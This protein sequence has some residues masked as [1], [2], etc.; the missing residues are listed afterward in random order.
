MTINVLICDDEPANAHAWSDNIASTTG[1][2]ANVDVVEKDKLNKN[3]AI[4]INRQRS[5]R[6]EKPD[7]SPSIFD[8]AD[9]LIADY[10]LLY[11]DETERVTG[12]GIAR[13]VRGLTGCGPIIVLN[14]NPDIDFDLKMLGD[15]D[16]L[17]DL[18][19][20]AKHA[21]AKGLWTN[22][23]GVG[24]RPWHWP[25][26]LKEVNN[27]R[28]RIASLIDNLDTPILEFFKFN[29]ERLERI[30]RSA[31]GFLHPTKEPHIVTFRDFVLES[32]NAVDRRMA[33]DVS[34]D[35]TQICSIAA[36][37]IHKWLER[38]VLGPQNV[39]VDM[40]HLVSRYP[41]LLQAD[42]SILESY[43]TTCDISKLPEMLLIEEVLSMQFGSTAWLSR[44]AFWWADIEDNDKIQ[45]MFDEFEFPEI[46][47]VFREDTSDFSIES[48]CEEFVAAFHSTYD[49]RYISTIR[50][51]IDLKY[52]PI[53]RLAM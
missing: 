20:P 42:P 2:A 19:V 5:F 43:N 4:L 32:G 7:H 40:P 36:A 50:K 6:Q 3:L 8:D 35:D 13:L 18:N 39:L 52:G 17:A 26:L 30:S 16:S 51:G 49:R 37:R 33:Q 38:M 9:I 53:V 48:E 34:K 47:Y 41:L 29:K 22:S 15:M 11:L 28:A 12:E 10:D 31:L 24:F 23:S 25:L 14:Q 45:Q 21:P 1:E 46:E 27:H 44:P